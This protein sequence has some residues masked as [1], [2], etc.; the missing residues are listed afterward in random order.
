[1]AECSLS[2]GIIWPVAARDVTNSPPTTSDSLFAS[3]E[4]LAGIECRDSRAQSGRAHEA[5]QDEVDVVAAGKRLDRSSASAHLGI[6]KQARRKSGRGLIGKNDYAH[7]MG[8][9]L[10]A[11]SARRS[12]WPPVR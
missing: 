11:Q 9:R 5:V 2:T 4:C 12:C 7:V 1:M 6:W 8:A 3:R 10:L